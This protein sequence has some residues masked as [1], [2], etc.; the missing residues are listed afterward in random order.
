M[1]G[2]P[3]I[4][5]ALATSIAL[6]TTRHRTAKRNRLLTE[7]ERA[8]PPSTLSRTAVVVGAA[9]GIGQACAH[10]LA[11]AGFSVVAVGRD[12]PGRADRVV[13]FAQSE[14]LAA[15]CRRRGVPVETI[16]LKDVGHNSMLPGP[17][18]QALEQH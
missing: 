13:P 3:W 4:A 9:G 8:M 16:W 17:G 15:S 12:R 1:L 11:E 2:T 10:R 5:L 7:Q 14:Q 6:L 18:S